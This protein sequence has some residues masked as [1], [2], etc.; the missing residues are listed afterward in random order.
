MVAAGK[1]DYDGV[2]KWINQSWSVDKISDLDSPGA[3]EYVMLDFK[4]ADGMD[5]MLNNGGE[6]SKRIKQKV[7]YKWRLPPGRAKS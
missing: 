6:K 4:L 1:S 3:P 5:K 7:T 2:I